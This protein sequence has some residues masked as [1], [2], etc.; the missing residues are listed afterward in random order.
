MAETS[1][2]DHHLPYS[3][4]L[5]GEIHYPEGCYFYSRKDPITEG[6][7][8][9]LT[10]AEEINYTTSAQRRYSG[11]PQLFGQYCYG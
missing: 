2:E 10:S 5:P 1:S 11:H 3:G 6:G 7:T 8:D 9:N 4:E